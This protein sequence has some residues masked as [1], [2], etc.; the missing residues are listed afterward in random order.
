MLVVEDTR[1][2]ARV[3]AIDK[4]VPILKADRLEI[5]VIGGWDC[6]VKK[7]LFKAGDKAI[8]FEIDSAI[9]MDHPLLA[10]FDKA[11]LKATKDSDSGKEYAVT[12]TVRLRGALSQ[13]LLV[14]MSHVANAGQV[15]PVYLRGIPHLP[16]DTDITKLLDVMKYVSDEEAKLY[17]VEENVDRQQGWFRTWWNK[18]R[19]KVQGDAVVDGLLPFPLGHVKSA[20]ERI[21][22]SSHSFRQLKEE[23]ETA[24]VSIKFD[25]ESSLFYTDTL[26][27]KIGVAQRNFALRTEDVIYT[28]S[29]ALRVFTAECMRYIVR[30]LAGGRCSL[31]SWK[32]RYYAQSVPLVAYF[33]RNGIAEKLEAMNAGK[34]KLVD[35]MPEL[36]GKKV[37]IQGEMVGPDFNRNAE[38]VRKNTF[39]MYRVYVGGSTALLPADARRIAVILGVEYVPVLNSDYVL[40]DTIAE[41]LKLADASAYFDP[42]RMREGVVIKG[43]KTGKSFKIISNKWLEKKGK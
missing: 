40:P 6:V 4:I 41:A 20:E 15:G 38:N 13:G 5:A 34:Y 33:R 32:D 43:N 31:P 1:K 24:E 27:S 22:N 30:K 7:D 8:Y 14:E 39:Y 3:V 42:Q 28:R 23:G 19:M 18:L 25:G 36:G 11:Y 29:E 10:Q 21:Q 26:T 37:S 9:A 17:R 12:K 16:A 35:G 2:L